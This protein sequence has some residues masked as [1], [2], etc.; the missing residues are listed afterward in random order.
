M[1]HI[2]SRKDSELIKNVY[3]AQQENPTRGDFVQPVLKD[4]KDI[5][6]TFEEAMAGEM[7]SKLL[8]R[9][10]FQ[11]SFRSPERSQKDGPYKI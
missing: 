1:K 6:L 5:G 2:L 8:K 10:S 7:S 11:E 4:L 9:R 3:L